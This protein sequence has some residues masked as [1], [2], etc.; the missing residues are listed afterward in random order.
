MQLQ[1]P[2]PGPVKIPYTI[3][4]ASISVLLDSK[5]RIVHASNPVF[6][7]LREALKTGA[8]L[9]E[10]RS[11]VD[12]PSFFAKKTFG[13]VAV[14][15]KEVRFD[16][17]TVHGAIANRIV[18]FIMSGD[19][20]EPLALFLDRLMNNP[21]VSAR[22]DL[23]EWLQ[24]GN[25]PFTPDGCFLAFKAVRHDYKDKHTGTLDN[26]VGQ[27]VSMP[28][29][30][31]D[32][33]RSNE[34]SRGLHFCS[35]DYLRTFYSSG[36]KIVIVKIDPADVVA[37][38]TDYNRQKG[39]AWRYEV[40]GE[41]E[42][43]LDRASTHFAGTPLRKD[44]ESSVVGTTAA[45]EVV[46]ETVATVVQAAIVEGSYIAFDEAPVSYLT[47]GKAYLVRH[48]DEDGDFIIL[49]DDQDRYCVARTEPRLATAEEIALT[50]E[51]PVTKIK[52]GDQIVFTLA[53]CEVSE[54]VVYVVQRVD[55]DGD[56]WVIDDEGEED[57]FV[58]PDL[59]LATAEEI[60][61]AAAGAKDSEATEVS[62]ET[63]F[64]RGGRTFTASEVLALL[65]EHG[66]RGA[67]RLTGIPRTTLQEWH[68]A[69]LAG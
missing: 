15:D 19:D 11:L 59:R 43:G 2:T 55:A 6:R 69:I 68:K 39:R 9:D 38:P 67:S 10:I 35:H 60:A 37:I 23:Y 63:T 42:E 52:A 14:S 5:M 8:Q 20:I 17:Q 65:D 25:A 45:S 18:E 28:R 53:T 64:T 56:I 51:K 48:V 32:A 16:G 21:T 44:Y 61:A 47:D 1:T 7:E 24:S 3:T 33:E 22:D 29:D 26:S 62:T 54:G 12:I 41:L 57:Y 46:S 4:N 27:V 40:V 49:D 13:R 31:V 66:Q 34:C 50:D 58:E 36:D 30:Q